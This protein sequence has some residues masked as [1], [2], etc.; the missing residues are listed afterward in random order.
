MIKVLFLFESKRHR[1]LYLVLNF[2]MKQFILQRRNFED[3]H[4]LTHFVS[5]DFMLAKRHPSK[6]KL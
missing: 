3:Q 5:Q 4:L 1:N 2:Y 6:C